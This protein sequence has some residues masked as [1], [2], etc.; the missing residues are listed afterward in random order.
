MEHPQLAAPLADAA[1]AAVVAL[2]LLAARS[3]QA[4]EEEAKD[5]DIR[6]L[7]LSTILMGVAG[8]TA[9]GAGSSKS[10]AHSGRGATHRFV[11]RGSREP[12]PAR[13]EGHS[14]HH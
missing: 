1:P 10:G 5:V 6:A 2:P 12:A 7:I 3:A 14:E 11:A 9:V 13:A 8:F 4:E